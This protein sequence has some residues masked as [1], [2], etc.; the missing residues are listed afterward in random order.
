LSDFFPKLLSKA[1][2]DVE[3]LP[4]SATSCGLPDASSATCTL[5]D[6]APAAVGENVTLIVHDAF[7][8]KLA[9]ANGQLLDWLK[10]ARF[11]PTT[12]IE[13]IDNTAEP[14]FRNTTCCTPLEAPTNTDPNATLPGV[15][16]TPGA[17]VTPVPPSVTLWGLPA[18]LSASEIDALRLPA[19]VG[20]NVTLIVQ[21][22]PAASVDGLTGHVLVIGKSPG[23]APV[24]ETLEIVSGL[25]PEF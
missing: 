6:R 10:S 23:F 11:A 22:A 5:A 20:A 8:A 4:E 12:P 24:K 19:A 16:D 25:L 17:G 15:N 7:T 18:A 14:E 3:P 13:L 9:G 1:T 21:V 2:A